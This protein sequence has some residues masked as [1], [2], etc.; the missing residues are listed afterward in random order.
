MVSGWGDCSH[1]GPPDLDNGLMV[2]WWSYDVIRS[3]HLTEEPLGPEGSQLGGIVNDSKDLG[4]VALHPHGHPDVARLEVFSSENGRT[5]WVSAVAPS[6]AIRQDQAIGDAAH[7]GQVQNFRKLTADAS[8]KL[9]VSRVTLEAIDG[10]ANR[11]TLEECPWQ[12]DAMDLSACLRMMRAWVD[13]DVSA[14]A[15]PDARELLRTGGFAE[16]EGWR[17]NWVGHAYTHASSTVPFWNR[18]N[19]GIDRDVDE[20]GGGHALGQLI[21]PDDFTVGGKITIDVP[22]ASVGIGEVF[23]ITIDVKAEAINHRQHESYLAAFFRDP[24]SGD[25]LGMEYQGIAPVETPAVKPVAR[26]PA[27]APACPGAPDPAAGILEFAAPT[28]SEP[29]IVG[30]GATVVVRRTGGSRGAVSA[31]LTTHDGTAIAGSDYQPLATQVLF[32]DGESGERA[33]RIPLVRDDVAEPDET[34]TLV[35]SDPAG[36][37]AMGTQTTAVLTILDDDRPVA[38]PTQFIVGGTVSGLQGTGLVLRDV[39]GPETLAVAGN[40][41]FTFPTPRLDATSYDV[42]VDTQPTNPLQ[43]C[44]LANGSGRV[45]GANVTSI[46]VTCTTPAPSGSL[47]P[48]FGD[49]GRA[50]TSVAYSPNLLGARIGMALQSDGKIVL[51]GGLKL[52]RLN[53][54]GT[55]DRAFGTQGVADVVFENGA[56]DTAMD[57]AVQADGKIVV[58]G[59]TSTTAVGSDNF[60]LARFKPDGSPDTTFGTG[61]HVTTDFFGST[62][63]V[64]RVHLQDDGKILVVGLAVHPISPI[65]GSTLFAIARYDLDGAPDLGFANGGKTTDSPGNSFSIANGLTIQ[66][67]GKIVV[68]GSTAASGGDDADTGLVRYLGDG[69]VHPPGTRDDGFGPMSNG[70]LLAPLGADDQAVDVVT[71]GDGTIL[72]AVRVNSGVTSGRSAFGLAHIP[73]SGVPAPRLPQPIVTFTTLGDS[74]RAMLKQADGKIVVVGQSGN[75]GTNPDMAIVRF[76]DTGFTPDASFGT[77]GRLTVDFFAKIDGAEAVV[78]QADGKL[79]VGGFARSGSTTV[80]AAVRV[81][82]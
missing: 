20:D 72:A 3:N 61:G 71:L 66:S 7:L 35:L 65:S 17:S 8:L 81:A 12:R 25:G 62:D 70:T 4:E 24:A 60:A 33:V 38:S 78:Q 63:Q 31:L 23:S 13:F 68:A 14:V 50:V 48:S 67:D 21:N 52:L 27:P 55:L 59:T 6:S 43:V 74:P 75:Q 10:D 47:D 19:F 37:A 15:L 30:D 77:D 11:P 73:A 79:V 45:A 46:A 64:R 26:D 53:A 42:R 54:D 34:L 41:S 49:G 80:F 29:E 58:A 18:D 2:R 39:L 1:D 40:G 57:V 9:V 5:Y 32:A 28:F 56:L 44:T 69:Q 36:C 82:Q 22:L 16:L 51:V 76:D